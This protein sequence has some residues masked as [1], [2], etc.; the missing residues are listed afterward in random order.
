MND[1]K[2]ESKCK[3]KNPGLWCNIHKRRKA[4]KRKLR[5]GE[6]GY[7]KTLKIESEIFENF[8]NVVFAEAKNL[9]LDENDAKKILE[10][11]N[12]LSLEETLL[13]LSEKKCVGKVSAPVGS[14]RQ[15]SFCKR[16]CGHKKKNTSKNVADDPDS[17][18]RKA[19]RRWKCRCR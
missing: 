19:L 15:R 4:G 5:P 1:I 11:L 10:Y 7:P 12:D 3:S 6:K 2:E 9:S 14:P 13:F 16:M 17:C 18:I 8:E